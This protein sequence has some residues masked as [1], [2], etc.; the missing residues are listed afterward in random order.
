MFVE[1]IFAERKNKYKWRQGGSDANFG[2]CLPFNL[3]EGEEKE[4]EVT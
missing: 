1:K 4:E 2:R 3:I